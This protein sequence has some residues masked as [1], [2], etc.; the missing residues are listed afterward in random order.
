MKQGRLMAKLVVVC[1]VLDAVQV[2]ELVAFVRLHV[3]M[4]GRSLIWWIF[5]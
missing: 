2:N 1:G 5:L 3:G 4:A